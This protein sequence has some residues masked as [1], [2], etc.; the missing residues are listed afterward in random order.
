MAIT[1][2]QM[3]NYVLKYCRHA[4]VSALDSTGSWPSKTYGT[5]D[6]GQVE[7][8]IDMLAETIIARG[9]QCTSR[10]YST[11]LGSP[12][13][14]T[15]PTN[16]VNA[17]P[18][19]KHINRYWHKENNTLLAY[20]AELATTNFPADSYQFQIQVAVEPH[21]LSDPQLVMLIQREA[22]REYNS[23][24][25]TDQRIDSFLSERQSVS[26]I[27]AKRIPPAIPK[28]QNGPLVPSSPQAQ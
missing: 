21:T 2:L 7:S 18:V 25:A 3:V 16:T 22:A 23:M 11:T 24:I 1:K 4:P 6:A 14:I 20:D 26:E 5:S 10:F 19:G 12:G 28:P 13:T 8:L 27:S 15:F 9:W 17:V